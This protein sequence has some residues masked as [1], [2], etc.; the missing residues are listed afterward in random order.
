MNELEEISSFSQFQQKK[1]LFLS[2]HFKDFGILNAKGS[3]GESHQYITYVIKFTA[4]HRSN[5]M[6]TKNTTKILRINNNKNERNKPN[7][8]F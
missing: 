3:N 5:L 4:S 6:T 7:K 8:L 1:N 2:C